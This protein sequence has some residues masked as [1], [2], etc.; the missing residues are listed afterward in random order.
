MLEAVVE[1]QLMLPFAALEAL[2]NLSNALVEIR[3]RGGAKYC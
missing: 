1:G 3:W 2:F